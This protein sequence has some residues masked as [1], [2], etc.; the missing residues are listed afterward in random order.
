MLNDCSFMGRLVKDPDL[1]YTQNST[2]VAAF[3]IACER[4][5]G[6]READFINCVAW[7]HTAEFISKHFR[8]GNL[9]ALNGR[10]QSRKYEK[11]G[12]SHTVWEINVDNAYFTGERK[13]KAAINVSIPESGGF[14][15]LSEGTGGELPF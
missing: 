14:E 9:I 6:D 11:D 13:E 1:R 15:E 12:V 10:L 2:P 5:Y 4:D 3:T 8:K 7:R